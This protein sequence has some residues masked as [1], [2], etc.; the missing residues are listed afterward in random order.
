MIYT[1]DAE[2]LSEELIQEKV[3]ITINQIIEGKEKIKSIIESNRDIRKDLIN[4]EQLVKQTLSSL[5]IPN[6]GVA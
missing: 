1:C 5:N 6:K 2:T 3:I 4:M